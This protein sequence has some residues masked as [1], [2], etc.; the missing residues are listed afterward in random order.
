VA[1]NTDDAVARFDRNPAT[2]DLAP[3]GCVEDNDTGDGACGKSTDGLDRPAAVAV[4]PDGTSV[5]VTSTQDDASTMTRSGRVP[6]TAPPASRPRTASTG[7]GR[8]P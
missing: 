8:S 4:S 7:R 3:A 2:G 5:Y 1:S 6:I